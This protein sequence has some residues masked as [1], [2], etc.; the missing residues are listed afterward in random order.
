MA[1]AAARGG[2]DGDEMVEV[3]VS[4]VMHGGCHGEAAAAVA[5]M[6]WGCGGVVAGGDG[7]RVAGSEL[8][9]RGDPEMELVFGVGRKILPEKISGGGVVVA[10]GGV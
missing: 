7:R 1:M 5:V 8:V 2:G 6:A 9:D 3:M 10:G 4:V